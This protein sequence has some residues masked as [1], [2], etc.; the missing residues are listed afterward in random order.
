M[1]VPKPKPPMLLIGEVGL[2]ITALPANTDQVPTPNVG[3]TA[4]NVVLGELMHN[5]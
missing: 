2:F 4:A 1:F 3:V 5:A